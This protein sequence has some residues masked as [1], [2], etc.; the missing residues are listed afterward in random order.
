MAS[1]IDASLQAR[2][3]WRLAITAAGLG[4]VGAGIFLI[5]DLRV[6]VGL[7]DLE[8]FIR[9]AHLLIFAV[10]GVLLWRRRDCPTRRFCT[11]AAAM[12]WLPF[13]PSLWTSEE[14]A[15]IAGRL[16]Q[17]WQ[18]FVG[19]KVLFFGTA[20]MFPGPVWVAAAMLVA[21]GLHA[22][23]LWLHLDLGAPEA[24]V[25]ADEPWATVTYL[26]IAWFLLGYRTYHNRTELQLARLRAEA[27]ALRMSTDA[28]LVVRDLANTPLQVLEL[29]IGLLR[30][31]HC[32]EPA[33]L[34]SASHAIAR[35]R[36]LRDRL[37][38]ATVTSTS[39]DPEALCR[40]QSA[41]AADRDR[42]ARRP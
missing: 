29:A 14:T 39:P 33:I 1:D 41:I 18:P 7:R 9:A 3:D 8:F 37:P 21:L 30:E 2:S 28:F 12:M 32:G 26:A 19:H 16:G 34:D 10:V 4:G 17:S 36:S 13:F 42:T 20:A 38:V 22:V 35:L 11:I 5:I 23:L 27:S 15:A 6:G 31:R 25:P 24:L 40:L